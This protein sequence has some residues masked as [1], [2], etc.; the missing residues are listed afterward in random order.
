MERTHPQTPEPPDPTTSRSVAEEP[1]TLDRCA[2][3]YAAGAEAR[4]AAAR[5]EQLDRAKGRRHR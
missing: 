5:R 2:R 4:D 1:A 3:E